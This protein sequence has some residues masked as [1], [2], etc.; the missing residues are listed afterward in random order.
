MKMRSSWRRLAAFAVDYSIILLYLGLLYLIG[1]GVGFV[2]WVHAPWQAHLL[3]FTTLTLPVILYFA[4]LET[5]D[6]ATLGKRVLRLHVTN[7]CGAPLSLNRS[8]FRNAVKFLPWELS[9]TALYRVDFDSGLA[10]WQT[11]LFGLSLLG[12]ALYLL[13]LFIPPYRPLYDLVSGAQV[14]L[15]LPQLRSMS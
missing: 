1:R 10:L 6:G 9:H 5:W 4:L 11:A 13:G 15:F 14:S 8:L 7:L 12:A 3:G 2:T